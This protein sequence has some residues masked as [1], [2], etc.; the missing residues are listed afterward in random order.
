MSSTK[1][2]N[3][4]ETLDRY[5][6]PDHLA[7]DCAVEAQHLCPSPRVVLE[8][9]VGGGAFA[10]AARELWPVGLTIVGADFDPEA[11]GRSTCDIFHNCDFL[12]LD[13]CTDPPDLILG[14]PPYSRAEEHVR[15]ALGTVVSGG[16]V[17][18][19]L[20]LAFME[21]KRRSGFW[22]EYGEHLAS[23]HVLAERPSFVAGGGRDSC[24]YGWFLWK[25]SPD[26]PG[27]IYPGWRGGWSA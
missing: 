11:E 15:H 2:G 4:R 26:Q 19:L 17:G 20:R 24:A 25:L 16:V 8:P 23:V 13:L 5:Y 21:G 9:S 12:D 6:T 3:S 27:K 14:N 10:R 7:L 1:R 22:L 18:M